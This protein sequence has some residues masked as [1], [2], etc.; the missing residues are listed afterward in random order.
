MET[1]LL[2]EGDHVGNRQERGCVGV[3][4]NTYFVQPGGSGVIGTVGKQPVG[5]WEG[6]GDSL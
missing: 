5:S 2:L 1:R 6:D 4:P 3:D